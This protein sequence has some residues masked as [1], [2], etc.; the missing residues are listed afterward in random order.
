MN[1][2]YFNAAVSMQAYQQKL[3]LIA[4]N[5]ANVNT[6]GFKKR[7]AT[8]EDLLTSIK[9]QPKGFQQEGRLSPLGFTQGW[10]AKLTQAQLNLSQGT[11]TSTGVD[12]DIAIEGGGLFEI[13]TGQLDDN[14]QPLHGYTRDGGF[15]WSVQPQDPN[16]MYLTTKSGQFVLDTTDQPIRIPRDQKMVVDA[17]GTI[18][19]YKDGESAGT[20]QPLSQVKLVRVVRP[21]YLSQIGDNTYR[22]MPG[23][24]SANGEVVQNLN[25]GSPLEERMAVRQGFLEQSNVNLADEM[26]E[27]MMTQRAFQLSSRALT[28]SDQ[29]ANLANN[30]RS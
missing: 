27:L 28:T 1:S 30:L 26:T 25:Q 23:V 22:L 3:D 20:A 7:D 5:V 29:M 16:N 9:Q 14:G 17:D 11:I 10:G 8:F 12:T 6:I 13:L 24:T 19:A 2:S 4:N 18:R 21:E 15:Q